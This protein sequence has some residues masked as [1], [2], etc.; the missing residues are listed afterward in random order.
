MVGS[1]ALDAATASTPPVAVKNDRLLVALGREVLEISPQLV[2]LARHAVGTY[3]PL[4]VA[5]DGRVLTGSGEV[6]SNDFS[7]VGRLMGSEA[8]EHAMLW[9]GPTPLVVGTEAEVVSGARIRWWE[10]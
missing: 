8:W 4:A 2:V 9:V 10:L 6:L 3:G 1:L 5:Q 7:L